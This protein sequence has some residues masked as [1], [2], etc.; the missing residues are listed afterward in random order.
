[1]ARTYSEEGDLRQVAA[2][3]CPSAERKTL[4]QKVGDSLPGRGT[5]ALRK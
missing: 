4:G 5:L 3:C 1:M 2:E